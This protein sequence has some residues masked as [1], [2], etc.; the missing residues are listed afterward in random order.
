MKDMLDTIHEGCGGTFIYYE[1]RWSIY[2]GRYAC[3]KCGQGTKRYV[4][5]TEEQIEKL[6]EKNKELKDL[7]KRLKNKIDETKRTLSAYT[8]GDS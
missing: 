6:E 1:H 5:N 7:I 8:E 4:L 3:D 2:D